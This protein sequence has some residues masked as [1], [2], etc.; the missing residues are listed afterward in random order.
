MRKGW[1]AGLAA[2]AFAGVAQAEEQA[3]PAYKFP[4]FAE[5]LHPTTPSKEDLS[6]CVVSVGDE[7]LRFRFV[8]QARIMQLQM[9][10]NRYLDAGLEVN[11]NCDGPTQESMGT[12]LA[13]GWFEYK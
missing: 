4:L 2:A 6:L 9:F 1:I 5:Y 3:V 11:G 8:G 13:R 12:G 7:A 10:L